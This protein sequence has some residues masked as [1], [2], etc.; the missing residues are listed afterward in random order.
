MRA[1]GTAGG[2]EAGIDVYSTPPTGGAL[3][4]VS[5]GGVM[6][7]DD[8]LGFAV[9]G[10]AGLPWLVVYGVDDAK[11]VYWYHPAF[12]DAHTD[13]SSVPARV[14]PI[15]EVVRH[16]LKPGALHITALFTRAPLHVS[17]VERAVAAGARVPVEGDSAT[18]T[19]DLQ[20]QP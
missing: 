4:P 20:V 9:R 6:H 8:A 1:K 3:T 18:H 15:P 5:T 17:D 10:T 11:N 19:I 16:D 14:G 7:V 12:T 13:P 2:D